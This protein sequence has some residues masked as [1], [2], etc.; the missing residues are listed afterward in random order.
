MWDSTRSRATQQYLFHDKSEVWIYFYSCKNWPK[1]RTGQWTRRSQVWFIRSFRS[2][3]SSIQRATQ[4]SVSVPYRKFELQDF[5]QPTLFW[6]D[7]YKGCGRFIDILV[8]WWGLGV[9]F[10]DSI[11]QHDW[12]KIFKSQDWWGCHWAIQ[13][14]PWPIS[15][16]NERAKWIGTEL[17]ANV[18]P[19]CLA[20]D[21]GGQEQQGGKVK[22]W[23]F[24][25]FGWL[26]TFED[27]IRTHSSKWLDQLMKP[28]YQNSTYDNPSGS[29]SL[30]CR[31]FRN[32]R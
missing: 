5:L 10:L 32:P 2:S 4:N 31:L 16:W 6:P 25:S 24:Q 27:L 3:L 14:P 7:V 8:L 15:M 1:P 23:P 11:M 29:R 18:P 13:P 21:Y 26:D 28:M 9:K 17:S 12:T 20:P 22:H 19:V 30:H